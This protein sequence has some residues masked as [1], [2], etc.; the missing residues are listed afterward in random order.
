MKNKTDKRKISRNWYF[1]LL[2]ILLVAV[3]WL[4]Y[5]SANKPVAA[6]EKEIS[7]TEAHELY[8]NGNIIL[9]VRQPEEYEAGHI[10]GAILIPLDTLASRLGELPKNE[11]IVVVCRSGS[12]SAQ[13]RD[14]LLTAG[15]ED[16]TSMAGGMNEWAASDFE[17][18]LGP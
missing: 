14:I 2:F 7:V 17:I 15:F 8:N 4:I 3:G 12:R 18:E 1:G 9:D 5:K 10:P 13:G 6:I 16:V 11:K